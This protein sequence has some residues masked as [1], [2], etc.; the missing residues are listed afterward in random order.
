MQRQAEIAR[1]KRDR[2]I[3]DEEARQRKLAEIKLQQ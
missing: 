2:E 1:Q 3:A